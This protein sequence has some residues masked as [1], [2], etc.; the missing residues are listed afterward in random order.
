MTHEL[1]LQAEL[2]QHLDA[3]A[4]ILYQEA[5]PTELTTLEG[6]EKNVRALAQEHVLPQ[7]RNFFINTATSR[8]TGKQRTLTSI[9][10]KLTL[11]TAQAQQLQVKPGTRWSPY[12]EKCCWVVSANASYQRAE[13]DI[14]ML[15][16]VSISHS[17]LQRLVQREDWSEVEI[18]EPI[19]ELCLDG[20][21]IRLRTEEGQ[22][23]EW[24]E[25]KA[26]NL[27][28]ARQVYYINDTCFFNY[29]PVT[30][31]G[32]YHRFYT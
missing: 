3:I 24:R 32:K 6:I 12:M 28:S 23:G 30:N 20:G 15:T 8:R 9:L 21:M 4:A 25:Y 5:D 18:A 29:Y 31:I 10:G 13:Q 14:A 1:P 22:P 7:R 2:Q 17:T 27:H 19:Q 11:T 16:G 26:L